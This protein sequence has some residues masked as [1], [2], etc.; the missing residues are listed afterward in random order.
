MRREA[1]SEQG[2]TC[3]LAALASAADRA[4]SGKTA[5]L[6]R[7][8]AAYR[9]SQCRHHGHRQTSI[10]HAISLSCDGRVDAASRWS[11]YAAGLS[12]SASRKNE[13]IVTPQL[14]HGRANCDTIIDRTVEQLRLP[15][16]LVELWRKSGLG[17]AK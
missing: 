3:E 13:R 7:S 14:Q 1:R 17:A 11:V 9:L 12:R 16:H 6:C 15:Y 5:R 2:L 8:G 4:G 10:S